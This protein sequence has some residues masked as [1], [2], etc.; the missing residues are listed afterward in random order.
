MDIFSP[1]T[2]AR[3]HVHMLKRGFVGAFPHVPAHEYLHASV[4]LAVPLLDHV[5][6]PPITARTTTEVLENF[7]SGPHEFIE[8]TTS[9]CQP[10]I[11]PYT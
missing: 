2:Y 11:L 4:H 10:Q 3:T 5:S 1:S 6:L 9:S 8:R 7:L